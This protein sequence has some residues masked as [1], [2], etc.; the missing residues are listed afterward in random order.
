MNIGKFRITLGRVHK[1]IEGGDMQDVSFQLAVDGRSFSIDCLLPA[2]VDQQAVADE[3]HRRVE[4]I[5]QMFDG[6][7]VRLSYDTLTPPSVEPY[8]AASHTTSQI[9][10]LRR[11]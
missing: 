2:P 3:L 8:V 6:T 10:L 4:A 7:P 5:T 9:N 1:Q 11:P